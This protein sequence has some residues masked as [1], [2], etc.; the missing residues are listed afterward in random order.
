MARTLTP[1]TPVTLP[2]GAPLHLERPGQIRTYLAPFVRPERIARLES[3]LARR[4][5]HLT[6]LLDQVHDPHNISACLRSCDACG[7]Q[8]LH[9]IS[10]DGDPVTMNREVTQGTHRWLDIIYHQDTA[11]AVTAIK[12]AGYR[13][14]VS[15]LHAASPP[16]PLRD[17]P[18][19][20]PVCLVFGNE[21]DGVS[22][23]LREA[24]DLS[25]LV[26]MW[27]FVES[28]N[29]SVALGISFH[30]L[31]ERLDHELK[32]AL[33]SP[34]EQTAIL[35]GWLLEEVPRA[36]SVLTEVVR[37]ADLSAAGAGD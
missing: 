2:A 6:A 12:G 30:L 31:R 32:G 20:T 26:P 33:I 16:V 35:D 18:L 11:A 9:I 37:R 19:Q 10:E 22:E 34:S 29:I 8:T 13:I 7:I 1:L 21:R 14:M 15:E 17:L 25:F 24:A 27:G 36:R 3:V 4:T 28:L 5:F 23:A